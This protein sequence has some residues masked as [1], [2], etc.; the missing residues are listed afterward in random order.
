MYSVY[1]W[2][3]SSDI[4][5]VSY[6]YIQIYDISFCVVHFP[7]I[8]IYVNYIYDTFT[9]TS[10]HT[11]YSEYYLSRMNSEYRAIM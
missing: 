10:K 4:I 1:I 5:Y 8:Q 11:E 7:I 2:I 3:F 6:M 9:S